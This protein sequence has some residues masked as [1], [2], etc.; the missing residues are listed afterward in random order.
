MANFRL[1]VLFL[2][3]VLPILVACTGNVESKSDGWNPAISVN[4][5]V[6]IGTKDGEVIAVV[7]DLSLIHI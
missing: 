6:Y 4:G 2:I 5:T 1:Q 3:V 7:D